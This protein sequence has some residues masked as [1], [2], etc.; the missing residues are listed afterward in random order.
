[1]SEPLLSQRFENTAG[2]LPV[3]LGEALPGAAPTARVWRIK[4]ITYDGTN[5]IGIG[6]AGGSPEFAF[7]WTLRAGYTYS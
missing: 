4:L 5:V 7:A 6:W 2:G 1:M 3:Y